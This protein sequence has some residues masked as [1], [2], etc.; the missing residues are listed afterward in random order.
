VNIFNF[1]LG[2]FRKFYSYIGIKFLWLIGAII[3]GGLFE[4]IGIGALLPILKVGRPAE[5]RVTQ[6]FRDV[7]AYLDIQ[8]E[9]PNL[10]SMLVL[11]FLIKGIATLIQEVIILRVHT[12]LTY[13]LR[14]MMIEK[15]G[16]MTYS[17]F[18]DTTTGYLNNIVTIEVE[19]MISA[20]M[21]YVRMLSSISYV[22]IYVL[23]SAAINLKATLIMAVLGLILIF[24]VRPLVRLSRRYSIGISEANGALQ[25]SVIE[26]IQNFVYI[27]A[28]RSFSRFFHHLE[29]NVEALR[30]MNFRVR[31]VGAAMTA[32]VEPIGV[33]LVAGLLY[34]QIQMQGKAIE[35]FL[36]LALFFYRTFSKLLIL[37]VQWQK[38]NE[39]LGGVVTV[40]KASKTL[41]ENSE[42]V[43]DT[44][45]DLAKLDIKMD[46]VSFAYNDQP[47]LSDVS[48][49][50]PANKTVAIV[51]ESGAGK[52]TL[53]GMLTGMLLPNAGR[54]SIGN[55]DYRDLD[56]FELRSHF[57]YVT[58]EPVIFLASIAENISMWASEGGDEIIMARVRR[59]ADLAH[60]TEFI[61]RMSDSFD[62]VVGERGIRLSGGQRQRLA[63]ARELYKEPEIMIFDE[64]TSS[65]D[66]DSERFIQASIN[67]MKG[68]KT[69]III[70]HRLSTI[71][72]ADYIY[73]LSKGRLVESGTFDQLRTVEDGTFQRIYASQK[74]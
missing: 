42:K 3:A 59:A 4:S 28:T 40:E 35:E 50:I 6:T 71:R 54:I 30:R 47:A 14:M 16:A 27:K 46:G 39:S 7:L 8:P 21:S 1:F 18:S 9:L 72:N 26:F 41:D 55:I 43:G 73:V 38:F 67:E 22:V 64:A 45:V 25:H 49:S 44:P 68:E 56:K 12:G 33:I 32:S 70:A 65:L 29:V 48:L 23:I 2:N 61:E 52:T 63:I 17:Y 58:Q 19:R 69:L 53:F 24:V 62:T 11:I 34:Y 31:V 60:C 10:L 74:L 51:G 5:D 36:V 20:V 57:G 66:T 13:S 15:F 37:Q